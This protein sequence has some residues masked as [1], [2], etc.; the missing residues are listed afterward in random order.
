MMGAILDH[1][2]QSSV[3]ALLI[4]ALTLLFR[5]NSAGVRHGLWFVASLKFLFPFSLLTLV[6]RALFTDTVADSSMKMMARIQSVAVPFAASAPILVKP[7]PHQLSWTVVAVAIWTLGFI[8][9]VALWFVQWTRLTGIVR[10]AKPS[11]LNAPVPVRVTAELLEPGLV[12]IIRP[13]ILLPDVMAQRLESWEIDAILAHELCHLRRRDNLLALIHMLVEAVFW[14]Y[15]LVWLMGSRLV[16]ESERAC[17]E[18][19]LDTGKKPLDY[20]ET[21]LKVCRLTI[22][23][24]LPCASGISG[25]DLDRRITAIIIRRAIDDVDPNKILLLTGLGVFAVLTPLVVGGL[26]PAPNVHTLRSLVQALAT[27]QQ[28]IEP[29]PETLHRFRPARH[30]SAHH[31]APE[32]PFAAAIV[33]APTIHA[34]IPIIILPEPQLEAD[35]SQSNSA[36]TD[37]PVCRPPQ[38]LPNSQLLGPQVCLSKQ[39]WDRYKARGLV[40]MPDGRT[41]ELSYNQTRTP[42]L[43]LSMVITASNAANFNTICRQ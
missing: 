15:P 36:E 2:W 14:F 20:A 31:S 39:T 38:R 26:V 32:F 35:S 24:P 34:D 12:G 21:I 28:V 25:S 7:A 6:G 18:G 5:N 19:V 3:V 17:D 41:L 33:A 42:I 30:R 16:E 13:V 4:G 40:L 10:F 43:C 8:A 27:E 11:P 29:V 9:I 37:A 23:S 1:L 22:R